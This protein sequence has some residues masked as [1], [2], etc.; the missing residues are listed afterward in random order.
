M[1]KKIFYFQDI[2]LKNNRCSL[3]PELVNHRT[4]KC[5]NKIAINKYRT[6]ITFQGSSLICF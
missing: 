2:K 3:H 6:L 1:F 5:N 4:V